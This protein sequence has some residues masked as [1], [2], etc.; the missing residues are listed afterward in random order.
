VIPPSA[1]AGAP[2]GGEASVG[3]AREAIH[4]VTRLLGVA[5]DLQGPDAVGARL[6]NE[7]REFFDV[8]RAVLLAVN[9]QRVHVAATS[10]ASEPRGGAL[11][12]EGFE[13]LAHVVIHDR[14]PIALEGEEAARLDLALESRSPARTLLA[15][16]MRSTGEVLHVLVLADAGGRGFSPEQVEVAS[17]FATAACA[18]LA[19]M[20]LAA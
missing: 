9:G 17:A 3:G 2:G 18:S 6:V 8:T 14:G 15:V 10:P 7:A 19:Q 20:R 12:V 1:A 5:A 13:A 4:A 16:P 11:P